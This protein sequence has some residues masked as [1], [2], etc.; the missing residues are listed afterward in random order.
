MKAGM[1]MKFRFIILLF[2]ILSTAISSCHSNEPGKKTNELDNFERSIMLDIR[3]AVK[4]LTSLPSS[5]A[6]LGGSRIIKNDRCFDIAIETGKL[7][8]RANIPV[9]TGGGTGIMEFVPM[10]FIESRNKA[11]FTEAS[12]RYKTDDSER[13]T[14]KHNLLTQGFTFSHPGWQKSNPSIEKEV[15]F[16][17][18]SIRK[19]ALMENKRAICFFPGGFGTEDE[20]YEVWEKDITEPLSEPVVL[21]DRS[22]WNTQLDTL[23]EVATKKRNLIKS[24]DIK[25]LRKN[26]TDDPHHLFQIICEKLNKDNFQG[27]KILEILEKD[28]ITAGNAYRNYSDAVVFI[29]SPNLSQDDRSLKTAKAIA[30][31]AALKNFPLR[32]GRGGNILEC[33]INGAR[34]SGRSHKPQCFLQKGDH[35]F[36]GLKS[37]SAIIESSLIHKAFICRKLL[38]L[39]VLPGDVKTLSEFFGILCLM[40]T[41]IIPRKPLILVG[42]DY[43]KPFIEACEKTMLTKERQL[44]SGD[45]FKLVT[46]TDNA[47]EALMIIE[48]NAQLR[49]N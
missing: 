15:Q 44:I 1:M 45:D 8:G 3:L 9:C 40:Q 20:F 2:V 5:V 14:K 28:L 13:V 19:M 7:L 25:R 42:S 46:V 27:K 17:N 33:M 4:T 37:D 32:A 23:E 36:D 34:E 39:V 10:G 47:D 22:Y 18:L 35:V 38:T 41:R 29:G 43:W 30:C 31:G 24:D 48:K 16:N 21:I 6:F 12:N 11:G 26:I 49:K